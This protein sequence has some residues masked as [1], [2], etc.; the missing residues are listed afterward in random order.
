MSMKTK[1]I[2]IFTV[3]IS[4]ATFAQENWKTLKEAN[5]VISYPEN[6]ESSDQKSQ[7]NM[8]FLLLAEEASQNKDGFREKINLS[9]EIL[10]GQ[11]FKAKGYAELSVDNIK[12]QIPSSNIE[13]NEATK[14]DGHNA[15]HVVW[16]ADFGNGKML[17][18]KQVFLVKHKT[19]YIL[20]FSTTVDDYNNYIKVADK[21]LNSF[22]MAK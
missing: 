14:I 20:T 9:S 16:S 17:K 10:A 21:V 2:T 4:I 1:L 8:L 13:V 7:S 3:F 15:W 19:A 18:F 12:A 5:Y 6:W 22:K 11:N